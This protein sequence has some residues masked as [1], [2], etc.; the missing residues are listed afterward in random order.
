[1]VDTKKFLDS[2]GLTHFCK[3][4]QDY[5]DNEI[6]STVINAIDATKVDKENGKVLSS[7]D[8]TD[9]DKNK[10]NNSLLYIEQTLTEEQQK[11]VKQNLNL[12]NDVVPSIGDN[13]N[14]FIGGEDTGI[15]AV[16]NT[17][18]ANDRRE[19]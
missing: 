17:I 12:T 7:N 18:P 1:M 4:L 5:P 16:F 8:Y 15:S 19:T 3:R 11:Q 14:W 6:L 9:E 10:L 13:G 2:S